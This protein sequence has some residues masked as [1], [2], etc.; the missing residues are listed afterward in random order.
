MT[1]TQKKITNLSIAFQNANDSAN[2]SMNRLSAEFFKEF[3]DIEHL[4]ILLDELK[5]SIKRRNEAK[6]ELNNC[7]GDLR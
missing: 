6:A 2:Y 1:D 4:E 3:V 7:L 5:Y